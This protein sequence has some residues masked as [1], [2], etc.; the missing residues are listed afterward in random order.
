[1]TP[2]DVVTVS[3]FFACLFIGLF[4]R[5][6]RQSN[7]ARPPARIRARLESVRPADL[8]VSVTTQR[9]DAMYR[10]SK[11]DR[12]A[13]AWL[14]ARMERLRT[15][16][17]NKGV[18]M[19]VVISLVALGGAFIA[20]SVSPLPGWSVPL[21]AAASAA[22]GAVAVYRTLNRRF[23][24]RFLTH[25]P[26]AIDM[27]IRAVRAGVP[28]GQ[29]IM[30]AASEAA[31]PV[32]SEFKIMGDSLKLGV[33]MDEVLAVAVKRVQL[34]D[35]SFFSV[36]LLLQRETGGQLG[37]TLENLSNIIRARR[38]V[39]LKSKALTGEVRVAS[40]IIAAVPF[41]IVGFLYLL[42]PAYV[43]P[44]FV[45]HGGHTILAIAGTLL[46]VGLAIIS[47]M[48]RLETSR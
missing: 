1:M 8:D 27:I 42:N 20:A 37:E 46:T 30:T 3:A 43:M 6:A 2:A 23:R 16:A 32:A 48:A 5:I 4:I 17:G 13:H 21:V 35:F 28:V 31:E 11:S 10:L 41:A 19:T 44:L 34:P 7:R 38:E 22:L 36:C 47:K 15:V 18:R 9:N 33:D 26:D 29:S 25:F 39:R 12:L 24:E 40:K 14:S 45:E